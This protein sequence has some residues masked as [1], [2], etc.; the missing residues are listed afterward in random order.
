MTLLYATTNLITSTTLPPDNAVYRSTEDA[1]YQVENLYNVR[2]SYPFRFT[3]KVGQYVKANLG[4]RKIASISAI[5]EHNLTNAATVQLHASGINGAWKLVGNYTWRKNDMYIKFGIN[6]IWLRLS[7]SDAGNAT[8]PILG[9]WFVAEHSVFENAV[10]T[11]GR[12]DG[13]Q[14][15]AADVK[16]PYGQ[17]WRVVYSEGERFSMTLT[18]VNDPATIDDL[19]TFLS[20][21]MLNNNGSFLWI[22]ND[23]QPHV[24]YVDVVNLSNYATRRV[25]GTSELR[26]WRLEFEI[27]TRGITLLD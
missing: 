19:Q 7:V 14:F 27:R 10:V 8:N 20:D 9:E 16:T 12:E 3:S 4:T 18:N 2:P 17:R 22:P 24:Y 25:Y 5:F 15:F 21:V 11:P 1:N 26:D 6:E 13:P 23:T